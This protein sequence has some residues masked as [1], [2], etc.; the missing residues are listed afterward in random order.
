MPHVNSFPSLNVTDVRQTS[1][2]QDNLWLS[3][4]LAGKY[5][6]S[7]VESLI[8]FVFIFPPSHYVETYFLDL[9]LGI[10]TV[11]QKNGTCY[12]T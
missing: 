4:H 9:R 12:K 11:L 5:V 6:A 10:K 8:Y 2:F 7:L 1:S 3:D